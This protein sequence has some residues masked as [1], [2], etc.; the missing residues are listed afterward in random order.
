MI[1]IL[2]F[3]NNIYIYIYIIKKKKKKKKKNIFQFNFKNEIFLKIPTMI[4]NSLIKSMYPNEL[5][6]NTRK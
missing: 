6:S 4:Y 3:L 1:I 5:Q 2:I